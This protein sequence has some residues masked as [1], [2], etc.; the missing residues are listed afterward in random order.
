MESGGQGHGPGPSS[1]T[2]RLRDLGH[3]ARTLCL[4]VF[5]WKAGEVTALTS[6]ADRMFSKL[7]QE[8]RPRPGLSHIIQ[9]TIVVI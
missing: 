7:Q 8:N 1:S 4:N 9:H 2:S 3:V 5:I 6:G